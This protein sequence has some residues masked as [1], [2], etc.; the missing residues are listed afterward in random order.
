MTV[1]FSVT[2]FCSSF[3]PRPA[4][5]PGPLGQWR[6]LGSERPRSGGESRGRAGRGEET[7]LQFIY[8][9][10]LRAIQA[11]SGPAESRSET[12][13]GWG[14]Q[15]QGRPRPKGPMNGGGKAGRGSEA[16]S[17]LVLPCLGA[18]CFHKSCRCGH[19]LMASWFYSLS[20]PRPR[21]AGVERW[22]PHQGIP[23]ILPA[24]PGAGEMQVLELTHGHPPHPRVPRH[25]QG[26]AA[27]HVN[28]PVRCRVY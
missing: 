16:A 20:P 27:P 1:I 19:G 15:G 18:G 26:T 25:P 10:L 7:R 23:R 22:N 3:R 12:P 2:E 11:P 6:A 24:C 14:T 4:S 9:A 5:P 28:D 8:D 21:G 17:S 13:R